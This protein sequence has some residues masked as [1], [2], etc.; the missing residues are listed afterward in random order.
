MSDIDPQPKGCNMDAHVGGSR[1]ERFRLVNE[2][3]ISL[4]D[5]ITTKE[6]M[7]D[8]VSLRQRMW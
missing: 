6:R 2:M 5:L 3:S 1:R 7:L 8:Y 4:I